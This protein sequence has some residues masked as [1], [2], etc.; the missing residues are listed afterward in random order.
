MNRKGGKKTQIES[1]MYT[2]TMLRDLRKQVEAALVGKK[3]N[4]RERVGKC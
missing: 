2:C 1:K 4:S 3:E